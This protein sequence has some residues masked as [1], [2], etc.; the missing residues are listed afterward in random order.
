M[1]SSPPGS[2]P[3]WS[4]SSSSQPHRR[5]CSL[6]HPARRLQRRCSK[7]C[8]PTSPLSKARAGEGFACGR[9]GSSS[10]AGSHVGGNRFLTGGFPLARW[11]LLVLVFSA[12]QAEQGPQF[13]RRTALLHRRARG[14][15][16]VYPPFS[17]LPSHT[18]TAPTASS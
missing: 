18:P 2:P 1:A 10:G 7:L 5:R 9:R 13:D 8:A 14:E 17:L 4:S 3:S 12:A 6:I 11:L 16:S 15:P